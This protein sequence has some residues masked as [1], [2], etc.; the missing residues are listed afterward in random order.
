MEGPVRLPACLPACLPTLIHVVDHSHELRQIVQ[1]NFPFLF[2]PANAGRYGA[3][4]YEQ[5]KGLGASL[6]WDREAFTMSPRC[7]KC[8]ATVLDV[9]L[10]RCTCI[11]NDASGWWP[12]PS[13]SRVLTWQGGDR[14]V[15][16]AARGGPDLPG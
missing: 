14:G 9:G 4:I 13:C 5:L 1:L 11:L 6:D 2:S 3:R 12:G 8:V 15:Y 10:D 16:P 7:C